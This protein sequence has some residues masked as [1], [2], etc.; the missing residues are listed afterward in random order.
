MFSSTGYDHP[1][2]LF[3]MRSQPVQPPSPLPPTTTIHFLVNTATTEGC[4]TLDEVCGVPFSDT[5][6]VP[7][8]CLTF[9]VPEGVDSNQ[10][11]GSCFIWIHNVPSHRPCFDV[12]FTFFR[13]A[14]RAIDMSVTLEVVRNLH[15]SAAPAVWNGTVTVPAAEPSPVWRRVSWVN[16]TMIEPSPG[17]RHL[18]PRFYDEPD[19]PDSVTE[20]QP[21]RLTMSPQDTL[22]ENIH[23]LSL[24]LTFYPV[25]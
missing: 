9:A 15:G 6:T 5:T 16:G 10:R 23:I 17:S 20:V 22:T 1:A 19:K 8:G 4:F 7:S 14:G 11:T 18:M 3:P 12:E 2:P 21:I 25:V 24:R 13:S